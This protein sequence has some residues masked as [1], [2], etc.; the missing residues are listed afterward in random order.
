MSENWP[1][2]GPAGALVD[3]E[4]VEVSVR[5][6]HGVDGQVRVGARRLHYSAARLNDLGGELLGEVARIRHVSA[7]LGRGPGLPIRP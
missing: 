4:K 5:L 7:C 2:I 6:L 3:H 1:V